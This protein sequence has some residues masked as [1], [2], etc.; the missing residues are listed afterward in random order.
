MRLVVEKYD[1][2]V[3]GAG[4][5]GTA[6][7]SSLKAQGQKVAIAE[8]DLWGGTCPNRG[9]DPKKILYTA[10]EAK[11]R[12]TFSRAR[13]KYAKFNQLGRFNGE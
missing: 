4:P 12:G 13:F 8:E 11:E 3:I 9:C 5:A 10:V 7:A 2:V 6:A 1:T